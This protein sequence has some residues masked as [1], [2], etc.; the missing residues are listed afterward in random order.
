MD[1]P[2]IKTENLCFVY[3]NRTTA[4]EDVNVEIPRGKKIV[5]LGPNGAGKSTLF[6]HFNGIFK[7]RSGTVLFNG[8][9][10]AYGK[11]DLEKLR[12]K[13]SL[14]MQNPDDQIFSATIEEDIAFGPMNMGLPMKEVEERVDEALDQVDMHGL[15]D[16]PTQQLSF[17][18]KKRVSLAGAI[19]MHP[20]VLIM[21]EPTAGLDSRMVHELLELADELNQKGLT[22]IM[23]THD[24]ETAYSW[25]DE[26]R[27]MN[28]GRII[29][30]GDPDGFFSDGQRARNMG[31]TEPIM[32]DLNRTM[33]RHNSVPMAPYPKNIFELNQKFGQHKGAMGRLYFYPTSDLSSETIKTIRH[34]MPQA[35]VGLIGT[36]ARKVGGDLGLQVEHRFDTYDEALIEVGNGRD[37]VMVGD[38]NWR[39]EIEARLELLST[40]FGSA[41]GLMR[42]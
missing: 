37:F 26:V 42:L 25:A 34:M 10:V 33:S 23:S 19:A 17:G 27:V 40:T 29:Y 2:V 39:G 9:P 15:R 32:F 36:N 30:S 13:V 4:L 12:S 11:K 7:P 14:V 22:V 16:K 18:Q 5:L 8:E 35:A 1:E 28:K 31:L 21:D 3:P 20:E 38:E 24:V 6:L 41:V